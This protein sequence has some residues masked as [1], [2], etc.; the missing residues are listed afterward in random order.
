MICDPCVF[1]TSNIP[2]LSD[3]RQDG[4][5]NDGDGVDRTR[6]HI[7]R[8]WSN[9]W[10]RFDTATEK[11]KLIC[12]FVSVL[13]FLLALILA[14][15]I[16]VAL[17]NKGNS[18]KWNSASVC[19]D[20]YTTLSESYRRES[21]DYGVNCDRDTVDGTSWYR[22]QLETGENGVLDHCPRYRTCGTWDP[23]WMN[24]THP[25]QY[26]TIKQVTMY[27]SY[28]E[29]GDGDDCFLRS[30]SGRVTK[31]WVD[32]DIFYLYQLWKPSGCDASYCTRTY[33][34]LPVW[35]QWSPWQPCPVTCGSAEQHRTRTCNTVEGECQGPNRDTQSCFAPPSSQC[36]SAVVC[37]QPYTTLSESY[38]RESVRTGGNCEIEIDGTSWY[39]F[40]LTTGEYGAWYRFQLATGENGVLDHCPWAYTCG[41][42]FPIWMNSTHPE[43]F[44]TIKQV[45]MAASTDTDDGS[46]DGS[47]FYKS[48]SARVTKCNVDGDIFYLY[49]LW[50]PTDYYGCSLSYCTRK[51]DIP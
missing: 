51:Y 49:Q 40:N 10:H 26:G 2:P 34:Y 4:N 7:G 5:D 23:I 46:Y 11:T 3:N 18:Y 6:H 50:R 44:G 1:P 29:R 47:C 12:V 8:M 28:D 36:P 9:L 16:P 13:F 24:S 48:G 21:V 45:T 43:E 25:E 37:Y 38:R 27:A 33:M 41:A 20:N 31:C 17:L 22:F 35:N 15:A 19:F 32:G 14:I 42:L 30:G 39:R